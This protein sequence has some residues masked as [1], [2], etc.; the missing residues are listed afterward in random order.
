MRPMQDL[1]TVKY[2][3]LVPVDEF[4]LSLRIK[5][6]LN[7]IISSKNTTRIVSSL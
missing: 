3:L 4:H 2:A 6:N 5:I 7:A 1:H